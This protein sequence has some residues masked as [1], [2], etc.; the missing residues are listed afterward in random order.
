M[1]TQG[2]RAT[3]IVSAVGTPAARM[4]SFA[5]LFEPS[6]C[7]AAALGPKTGDSTAPKLVGDARDKRRL[8]ADHDEVGAERPREREQALA[9]LGA[10][11]V[12]RAEPGDAGVPGRRVELLDGRA[13]RELPG[14]R[15]LPPTGAD[16]EDSHR[17]NPT[18]TVPNSAVRCQTPGHGSEEHV[19]LNRI[20]A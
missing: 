4:T 10:N 18:G 14:Q 11:R 15:M 20:V 1:T 16:D 5:K 2:T 3:D 13:L 6:I 9:V 12:T 17:R 19:R 7:A 8:G